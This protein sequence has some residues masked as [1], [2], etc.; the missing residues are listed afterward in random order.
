MKT[1]SCQVSVKM[2]VLSVCK[3]IYSICNC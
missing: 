3:W 1:F 2:S